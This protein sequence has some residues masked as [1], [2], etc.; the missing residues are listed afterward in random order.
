MA[1]APVHVRWRD[2]QHAFEVA[3]SGEP[4]ET[5][6]VLC[7]KTGA[8]L[9]HSDEMDFGDAWPDDVEGEAKYTRV[10]H[11]KQLELGKP[12]VLAFAAE[13][14]PDE[15]EEVRKLF[16][17]SGAYRRFRGM[18][19]RTRALEQWYAFEAAANDKALRDWCAANAIIIDEESSQ[20]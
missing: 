3:S 13:F 6:A 2:L 10:P 11:R 14:L 1:K 5:E 7:R 18:L 4:G 20:N 19:H 15:L 12:L 17:R 16:D 8:F 9:L